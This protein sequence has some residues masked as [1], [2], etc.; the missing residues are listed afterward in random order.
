[1]V[2]QFYA[3]NLV[4]SSINFSLDIQRIKLALKYLNDAYLNVTKLKV[5]NLY[6]IRKLN[7]ESLFRVL[8]S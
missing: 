3:L 4:L 6:L 1:M 5:K 7:F 2:Y 8:L